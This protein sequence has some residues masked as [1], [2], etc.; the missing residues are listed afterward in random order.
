MDFPGDG[1]LGACHLT[2]LDLWVIGELNSD[3]NVGAVRALLTLPPQPIGSF[4]LYSSL[5]P[6]N[7]SVSS[8][9][10]ES[11]I[12]KVHIAGP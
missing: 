10:Q 3:P 2:W 9:R 1:T 8:V 6:K 7:P 5:Q 4:F 11:F 12:V